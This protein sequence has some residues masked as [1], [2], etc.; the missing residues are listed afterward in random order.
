MLLTRAEEPVVQ[1]A[2]QAYRLAKDKER[3]GRYTG[4]TADQILD[5]LVPTPAR[6]AELASFVIE[7]VEGT[8]R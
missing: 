3:K 4:P 8:A 1:R 5:E 7:I 2:V 6:W